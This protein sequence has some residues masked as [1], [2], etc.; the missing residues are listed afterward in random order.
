M[1]NLNIFYSVES[2]EIKK[3]WS[4]QNTRY[5]GCFVQECEDQNVTSGIATVATDNS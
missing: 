2:A 3:W 1:A 5:N 4:L